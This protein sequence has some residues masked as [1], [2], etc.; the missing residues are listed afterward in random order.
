MLKEVFSTDCLSVESCIKCLLPLNTS[1][2]LTCLRKPLL[3][4]SSL[5]ERRNSNLSLSSFSLQRDEE[6]LS[7]FTTFFFIMLE[8]SSSI[9]SNFVQFVF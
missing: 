7:G 6:K 5:A 4:F 8:D 1:A 3:L 2:I 9:F